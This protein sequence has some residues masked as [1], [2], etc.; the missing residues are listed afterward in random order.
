M[1][2]MLSPM[3]GTKKTA[4]TTDAAER[5]REGGGVEEGEERAMG[6]KEDR[7]Q[8]RTRGKGE[9]VVM[10]MKED[11]RKEIG[12]EDGR[13]R[14]GHGIGKLKNKRQIERKKW[15]RRRRKWSRRRRK[16]RD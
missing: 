12:R 5:K 14:G 7:S 11:R 13:R 1:Q 2:K 16:N 10:G 4:K 6:T 8:D 15:S 9:E 3:S